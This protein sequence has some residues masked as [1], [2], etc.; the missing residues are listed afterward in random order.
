MSKS[1]T[2]SGGKLTIAQRAEIVRRYQDG[3]RVA[4]LAAE[5][6]V[7]VGAIYYLLRSRQIQC[8]QAPEKNYKLTPAQRDEVAAAYAEGTSSDLLAKQYGISQNSVARIA[9][10]RGVL[11]RPPGPRPGAVKQLD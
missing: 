10:R 1:G 11:A 7:T 6:D 4:D 9:A 5:Y 2:H 3:E 8:N